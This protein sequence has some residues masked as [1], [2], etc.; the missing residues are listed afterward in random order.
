M[1]FAVGAEQ[2][3]M[4]GF[5][6]PRSGVVRPQLASL[7]QAFFKSAIQMRQ[8]AGSCA[9]HVATHHDPFFANQCSWFVHLLPVFGYSVGELERLMP[10]EGQVE[11]AVVFF[12]PKNRDGW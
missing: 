6:L 8:G 1:K 5:K 3:C 12:K 2:Q 7:R 10:R 11:T 9:C 4:K